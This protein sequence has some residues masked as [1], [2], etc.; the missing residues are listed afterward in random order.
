[1]NN[2]SD[3]N[4]GHKRNRIG[5]TQCLVPILSASGRPYRKCWVH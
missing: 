5:G 2:L 3:G 1:M 4:G